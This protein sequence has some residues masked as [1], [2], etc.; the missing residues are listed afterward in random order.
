M[1]EQS[2]KVLATHLSREAYLYI[3]QSTLRQVAE[4][5]ES[6][7]RQYALR[8]R[9]RALGWPEEQVVTVDTDLGLSG[10]SAADRAG[11]QK[12][13]ADVGMGRVGIVLGL[14]VSRLARNCAD[15]HRLL[16]ICAL[17]HTLIMDEDGI[18]DPRL[19]N[20]RLLLGLKGAMSEAEQHVIRARLQGGL[21]NK[22]RRGE[23]KLPLPVG[24][25]YDSL[26]RVV[27][28]P[29][30]QVQ[31]VLRHFFKTFR[32]LSS[33]NATVKRLRKEGLRF[34]RRPRTMPG[35]GELF[36]VKPALGMA[37]QILHNPRYAGAFVYGR[38]RGQ[39][40]PDGTHTTVAVA[41]Q[42]WSVLLP[43]THEGY[44]S[45]EQYL[46]NQ[47]I[48]RENSSADGRRGRPRE[49]SALLQGIVVCG[50]CGSGMCPRYYAHG[51]GRVSH[52]YTCNGRA[53][54]YEEKN[55]P[56]ISGKPIDIAV[57]EL[58]LEMVTPLTLE[59]ALMVRSELK[60]RLEA[61]DKLRRLQ[62]ERAQHE[63]DLARRRYMQVDPDNRLVADTLEA[64]W[65]ARLREKRKAKEEYELQRAADEKVLTEQ[66]T[67]AIRDLAGNFPK[68]W[69]DPAVPNQE[70]KRMGAA[71]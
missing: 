57:S 70:R 41:Q 27:L 20:D 71:L 22:A 50:G 66:Q 1:R 62:V 69:N 68:L 38:R 49:G 37:L 54:R 26:D 58:Q 52:Y 2:Q 17:T 59:A 15:W 7:R 16:E 51:R 18:Y 24:L 63:V 13:V 10:A 4:N 39:R 11:F 65:N 9:A 29:D 19:F 12:L 46:E 42:E 55:C 56:S 44:L 40:R 47:R 32:E 3:R 33:A 34:P 28:D 23:L 5:Q 53:V 6:T 31:E 45:W 60:S 21:I 35:R 61:A 25:V 14:E 36:W 43:D 67:K 30:R 48:L 64:E 8:D